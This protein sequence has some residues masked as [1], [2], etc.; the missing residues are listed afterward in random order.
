MS[1][2]LGAEGQINPK[3]PTLIHYD[4]EEHRKIIWGANIESID[5]RSGAKPLDRIRGLKLLLDPELHSKSADLSLDEEL[6]K[7]K[8]LGKTPA[9]VVQDYMKLIY[10]HALRIIQ[11]SVSDRY[12]QACTKKFVVTVP[13][14]W[15]P[16][17]KY[18]TE[19][20]GISSRFQLFC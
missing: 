10:R 9:E 18:L 12:F 4:P 11:H 7:I 15:S 2:N 3:T 16:K 17:A 13:A 1:L 14:I 5:L 20:V 8:S 19:Q 6:L